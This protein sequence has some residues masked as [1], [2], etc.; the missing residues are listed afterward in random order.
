MAAAP[1]AT[2]PA[3]AAAPR[4]S[5]SD[6]AGRRGGPGAD[7]RAGHL[8]S[9]DHGDHMPADGLIASR[10]GRR[11]STAAT[12]REGRHGEDR[13][14]GSPRQIDLESARA[15]TIALGALAAATTRHPRWQ[16]R[17]ELHDHMA[18]AITHAPPHTRAIT[19]KASLPTP[20]RQLNWAF[21]VP[22]PG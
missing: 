15:R 14:E 12:D 22:V 16:G 18:K 4:A 17:A 5:S 8:T 21:V 10:A 11:R 7:R 3:P 6:V 9:G 1:N 13:R 20:R 19:R 2:A